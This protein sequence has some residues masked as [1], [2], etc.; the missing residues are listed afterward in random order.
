MF[1]DLSSPL[2]GAKIT[3]VSWDFKG[4]NNGS[5]KQDV[6]L[7]YFKPYRSTPYDCLDI[8]NDKIGSTDF[9]NGWD[10]RTRFHLTFSL[11]GG[12]YPAFWEHSEKGLLKVDYKY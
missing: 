5:V 8:S 9:F 3:Q 6:K 2:N 4:F 10:P 1:T 12:S 11:W 7:C